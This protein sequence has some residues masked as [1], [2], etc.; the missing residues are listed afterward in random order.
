MDPDL[1]E[2][3]KKV[4][5]VADT[6][7]KLKDDKM[8][9]AEVDNII[10]E[11]DPE[12]AADDART[13][14]EEER[15]RK[16]WSGK[17][18]GVNYLLFCRGCMWEYG[19]KDLEKCSR[20]QG[21]LISYEERNKEIMDKVENLKKIKLARQERRAKFAE[22]QQ[23]RQ[24]QKLR[25]GATDYTGWDVWEPSSSED[26]NVP[27]PETPEFKMMERDMAERAARKA[28]KA[29][30]AEKEKSAGNAAFAKKDYETA[31]DHYSKA[32]D[33]RRDEKT[34][35]LNR[36]LAYLHIKNYKDCLKDCNTAMDIVE[37]FESNKD[38]F[39]SP[40]SLKIFL[41]RAAAYEG[42]G[43]FDN[44]IEQ[45]E[46]ALKHVPG[47]SECTQLLQGLRKNKEE[48]AKVKAVTEAA[49]QTESAQE[50]KTDFGKLRAVV[51]SLKKLCDRAEEGD[52]KELNSQ[53]LKAAVVCKDEKNCV[54]FREQKGLLLLVRALERPMKGDVSVALITLAQALTNNERNKEEM[55]KLGLLVPLLRIARESGP[56]RKAAVHLL[57]LLS[58]K[59]EVRAVLASAKVI[60]EVHTTM[61]VLLSRTPSQGDN[62]S[63]SDA[64]GLLANCLYE[65]KFRQL[66]Q[67]ATEGVSAGTVLACV[68]SS[69]DAVVSSALGALTNVLLSNTLRKQLAQEAAQVSTISN[70]LAAL[71]DKARKHSWRVSSSDLSLLEKVMGVMINLS[72]EESCL[73]LLF[74]SPPNTST[75]PPF[76]VDLITLVSKPS[77]T[78]SPLARERACCLLSKE[79][80]VP[81]LRRR[82][83]TRGLAEALL[84]CA[85]EDSQTNVAACEHAARALA[86][87]SD[88][89][90]GVQ[91][92]LSFGLQGSEG[93]QTK[94][95]QGPDICSSLLFRKDSVNTSG[96]I[97]LCIANC[98]KVEEALPRFSS[99]IRP[100]VEMLRSDVSAWH[101]N[102]LVACARLA[103]HM[104][105]L[106]VLRE[107]RA[108]ELMAQLGG[109][110]KK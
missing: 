90:L 57:S 105:H 59:A 69:D 12:A 15:N 72:T 42:M 32:I 91:R 47:D 87:C 8:A 94:V 63:L 29:R 95:T 92:I 45:M 6:V 46:T 39:K 21:S 99:A 10:E 38:K 70:K 56:A 27:P 107:M 13:R 108:I 86:L 81:A 26:E 104:P 40:S 66:A 3:L 44:A 64:L 33:L 67:G 62:P 109:K 93:K 100:L 14:R 18:Y 50:T 83:M 4:D 7:A 89:E 60:Q 98:A 61:G 80:K 17:G 5:L 48:A 71:L 37:F 19:V 31:I 88:D 28:E 25:K 68:N 41:R 9:L 54:Y 82:A 85:H 97:A 102:T 2:F 36:A 96:N 23:Q 75:V 65:K 79:A 58:E 22:Y 106:A 30:E 24:K 51:A 55:A 34:F 101:S 20:C 49:Q 53:A 1:E 110:T 52:V 84:T 77:H 11:V 35:Y 73:E 16:G 74:L 43:D 78:L 103:R 76:L